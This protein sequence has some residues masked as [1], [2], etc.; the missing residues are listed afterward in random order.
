MLGL[1][2]T[3]KIETNLES[4]LKYFQKY[5]MDMMD[6]NDRV[7]SSA[8]ELLSTSNFNICGSEMMQW[9]LEL[10]DTK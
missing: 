5:H 8:H 6:L 3:L 7:M 4:F 1:M 2:S 9:Y 10:A